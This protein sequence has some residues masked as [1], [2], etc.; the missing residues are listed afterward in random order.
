MS[1]V[2]PID[3]EYTFDTSVIISQ[4]DLQGIITYVNRAF[5]EVSDYSVEELSGKQHNIV[6]HPDMPKVVF[7]KM[8]STL[9]SGQVWNGLIKNLRKDGKF[10]WV[11]IEILPVRDNEDN[12]TGYIAAAKSASRKDILE[13]EENYKKMLQLEED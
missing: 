3:D 4:T 12:I 2:T 11:E 6:R 1:K 8:W 9:T 7:E 5:C 10:Y 13:A